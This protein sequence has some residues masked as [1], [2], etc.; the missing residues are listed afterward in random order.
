METSF[1]QEV[2]L[3]TREEPVFSIPLQLFLIQR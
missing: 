2:G 3:S 1:E